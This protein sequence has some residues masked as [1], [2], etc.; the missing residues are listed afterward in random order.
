MDTWPFSLDSLSKSDWSKVNADQ[1]GEVLDMRKGYLV[2][3]FLLSVVA[4]S[5]QTSPPPASKPAPSGAPAEAVGNAKK[6][7]KKPA[8][9]PDPT[10]KDT[11]KYL[12]DVFTLPKSR[13]CQEGEAVRLIETTGSSSSCAPGHQIEFAAQNASEVAKALGSDADFEV[14][15]TG[16]DTLAFY[17]KATSP[18]AANALRRGRL[19]DLEAFAAKL[20]RPPFNYAKVV[21][22]PSGSAAPVAA[23]IAALKLA[24]IT[25]DAVGNDRVLLRSDGTPGPVSMDDLERRLQEILWD[26]PSAPPTQRLFHITAADVLG[27]LSSS[28]SGGGAGGSKTDTSGD[29]SGKADKSIGTD[30]SSDGAKASAD[31]SSPSPSIAVTV[32]AT[33]SQQGAKAQTD[34]G[35]GG[36]DASTP[37]TDGAPDA[38]GAAKPG[39]TAKASLTDNSKKAPD[40]PKPLTMQA[41]KDNLVYS[42]ADGGDQN[43]AE[44]TRLITMLDLPRPEVLLNMWSF[45]VSSPSSDVVSKS[46]EAVRGAVVH[47]N[48]LL[49]KA[50]ES[51]WT[52]LSRESLN[53]S[54]FDAGFYEYVTQKFVLDPFAENARTQASSTATSPTHS[55]LAS[56][57]AFGKQ[58]KS[59]GWCKVNTYCLGFSH[60]FDPL[61]PTFTNILLTIAASKNPATVA[62]ATIRKMTG[63]CDPV[64]SLQVES[65][66]DP[67]R[68]QASQP[69]LKKPGKDFTKCITRQKDI[70]EREPGQVKIT[71][72]KSPTDGKSSTGS[73]ANDRM[74]QDCELRDRLA[75]AIQLIDEKPESVQLNC[76]A[77]QASRSFDDGT[78]TLPKV[79]KSFFPAQATRVG[80][81]R[82]AIADFLFNYKMAQEYPHDFVPYD[83]TQSAQ[84]LNAEFNPLILAFNRD[85]AAFT[86]HLQ[87]E[88]Q[89]REKES[90][91]G[92]WV[93]DERGTFVNNSMIA[94]RGISGVESIVDT[95]TQNFFDATQP[96]NLT[97]LVKSV[98]DAEK[99]IPAVLKANLTSHEAAVLV[100]ALN[101]VQPAQAKIGRQFKLDIIPHA[102]A[103]AS[104]AELEVNLTNQESADPTLFKS[105]KSSED[106]LSRVAKHNTTTRVRVESLKLF[107]VSS[108]SAMLQRP[109]TR[110]PILP[111]FFEVPYFGSFLGI[112]LPGAKEYHRSTAVVSAVIVPTAADLAYG[113][114]FTADR[115]C[116][117]ADDAQ[118]GVRYSDNHFYRCHRSKSFEDLNGLPFRSYHKLMVQCFASGGTRNSTGILTFAPSLKETWWT[119]PCETDFQHVPPAE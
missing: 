1:Y 114:D 64:V 56:A 116:R 23:Q 6:P 4:L 111:P 32:T 62:G 97:D 76:F 22:V 54:F 30:K 35:G 40:S 61:R 93:G 75:L 104:S 80:L 66:C 108:F 103:S 84:E 115:V 18:D 77:D 98:S 14:L 8:P 105:G 69:D 33:G 27:G 60:A 15:P 102:L 21:P 65:T 13:F 94:V 45:Q 26:R 63:L 46:S 58:R 113:I 71:D 82:A 29:T 106:N 49:Q 90:D 91:T 37:G 74:I 85:V 11:K 34:A 78:L 19:A 119:S 118:F 67:T 87:T 7:V 101:S 79:P 59:W 17:G 81:L 95:L 41:V 16:S 52:Y 42:N 39:A 31:S 100:G 117:Q 50:I 83:L 12:L 3:I 2:A 47:H 44:R 5:A 51:G 92:K 99:N 70:L 25:A 72:A 96:P 86:Q 57:L 28:A 107:E 10:G 55:S 53:P 9:P 110:F 73:K 112:P 24:G 48:D 109:R 68:G 89:C 43:I 36:T 88:L 20:A 38:A